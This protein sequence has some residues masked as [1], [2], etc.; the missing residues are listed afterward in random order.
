MMSS[1]SNP[2]SQTSLTVGWL[3]L[4]LLLVGLVLLICEFLPVSTVSEKLNDLYFRLRPPQAPSSAVALVLIDD[5]SLARYGRWPWHRAQLA[6]LVR[7]LSAN[8]PSA[9][10]IDILLSEAQDET[11]DAEPARAIH[12]A[13]NAVLASKISSA[14][15]GSLWVDPL[16]RF[17]A[18]AKGVGHVQ[19]IIDYDGACRSIPLHEPSADGMRP[20]FALKLASLLNPQL[21]KD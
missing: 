11:N 17:L 9:V 4:N 7:A 6:Q 15:S 16:P 12:E 2:K 14:S 13:P 21:T 8:G 18:A 3:G 5:V 10:G 19:A 20:A 1:P